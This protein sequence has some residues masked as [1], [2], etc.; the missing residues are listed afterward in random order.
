MEKASKGY[1]QRYYQQHKK[2]YIDRSKQY[3]RDHKKANNEACKKWLETHRQQK[4]EYRTKEL[5]RFKKIRKSLITPCV[6]CGKTDE[7]AGGVVLH[8]KDGRPHSTNYRFYAKHQDTIPNDFVSLCF[9]HHKM[10][11]YLIN[12]YKLREKQRDKIMELVNIALT[13]PKG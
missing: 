4:R 9:K 7:G 1:H 11:H 5:L 10:V 12:F 8:K 2:Q 6:I 3:Y 13:T